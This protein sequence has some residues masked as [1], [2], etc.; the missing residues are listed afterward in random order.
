MA[1]VVGEGGVEDHL[2]PVGGGGGRSRF[3]AW[4][5]DRAVA[6]VGSC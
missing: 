6:V 4:E 2:R 3:V 1:G 5:G